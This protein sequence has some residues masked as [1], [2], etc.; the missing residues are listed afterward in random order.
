MDEKKQSDDQSHFVF[1]LL[2]FSTAWRTMGFVLIF[3]NGFCHVRRTH[4]TNE[5]STF[6]K[7]NSQNIKFAKKTK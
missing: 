6:S 3:Q 2:R 5:I 1:I 7:L 4:T